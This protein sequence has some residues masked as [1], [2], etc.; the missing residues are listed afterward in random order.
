MDKSGERLKMLNKLYTFDVLLTPDKK[1][2]LIEINGSNSGAFT[3]AVNIYTTEEGMKY[4]KE[5]STIFSRVLYSGLEVSK[6]RIFGCRTKPEVRFYEWLHRNLHRC[7]DIPVVLFSSFPRELSRSIGLVFGIKRH[8]KDITHLDPSIVVNTKEVEEFTVN[9]GLTAALMCLIGYGSYAPR[10]IVARPGSNI[11]ILQNFLEE[12]QANVIIKK[13]I[14][15]SNQRGITLHS[16]KNFPIIESVFQG[17]YILQDYVFSDLLEE[18][19]HAYLSHARVFYFNGVQYTYWKRASDHYDLNNDLNFNSLVIGASTKNVIFS[20]DNG[21][22]ERVISFVE[23]IVPKLEEAIV[24]YEVDG[25]FNEIDVKEGSP[26]RI[27][28]RMQDFYRLLEK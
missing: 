4:E 23:E 28:P 2:I 21:D 13:P 22:T 10:T 16:R 14:G 9:K 15:G 5:Y 19:G 27:T 7:N 18:E 1:P 8:Y 26:I 24:F 12:S 17:S 20:R 25:L 3:P 6:A 11:Q